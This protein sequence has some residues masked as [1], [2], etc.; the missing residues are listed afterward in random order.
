MN[1]ILLLIPAVIGYIFL[2]RTYWLQYRFM[3]LTGYHILFG[4]A[5]FGAVLNGMAHA[6]ILA[7]K[8]HYLHIY[9]TWKNGSPKVFTEDLQITLILALI[10]PPI[11]NQIWKDQN[12]SLEVAENHGENIELTLTEAFYRNIL[13]EVSLQNRKSYIGTPLQSGV[14]KNIQNLDIVLLPFFSAH[15]QEKDLKLVLDLDY[16]QVISTNTHPHIPLSQWSKDDFKIV[17]PMSEVVSVRLFNEELLND[18]QLQPPANLR[19][20]TSQ[21]QEGQLRN[22]RIENRRRRRR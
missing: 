3:R 10:I 17:I 14:R 19:R 13:V 16:R 6:I 15:R 22:Q 18:F 9:Q 1:A 7:I 4:S 12:Q 20:Q 2:M 21:P 8:C 11:L 5:F